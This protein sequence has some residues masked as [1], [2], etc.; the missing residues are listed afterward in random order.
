MS[1]ERSTRDK[2]FYKTGE[3]S[4][5]TILRILDKPALTYWLGKQYFN[6][7]LDGAKDFH[8]ASKVV[9]AISNKAMGTGLLVHEYMEHYGKG[10][11]PAKR[12]HLMLYYKAFHD[13]IVE[14]KPKF[15]EN[16]ITVTSKKLG[17]KGTCDNVSIIDGKRIMVDYKTGKD[18][19]E[20]VELQTSAY[21]QAYEEQEGKKIDE[22]WVLL[23]EKGDDGEPTGTYRFEQLEYTPEIFNKILDIFKW[24]QSRKK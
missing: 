15:V 24:Q 2:G 13:W 3:P 10:I 19:Y 8:E 18:I 7:A 6:A 23:L 12:D 22:T 9:K 20:S 5:T 4:V 21:R 11:V 1:D 14:H 17:Y 16:E